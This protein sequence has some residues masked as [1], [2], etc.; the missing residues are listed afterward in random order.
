MYLLNLLLMLNPWIMENPWLLVDFCSDNVACEIYTVNDGVMG[1]LSRSK[2]NLIEKEG[3]LYTGH[4][5]LDNNGGFSSVR[6]YSSEFELP[7]NAQFFKISVKADGNTYQ[8]RVKKNRRDFQ[9]YVYNFD[10]RGGDEVI[11][12]PIAEMYPSFRG[13]RLDME[14]YGG[15]LPEELGILIGNKKEQD[16]EL[17]IKS[18]G[19]E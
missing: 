18:I 12:I 19:F 3:L 2:L 17:L 4:V 13:R 5:S 9:S 11:K 8:F 15:Q 1:G 14:N 10:T 6:F 7:E 16:F